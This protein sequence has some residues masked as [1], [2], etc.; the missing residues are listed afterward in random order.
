M[1]GS[2]GNFWAL[3]TQVQSPT[4]FT[5]LIWPLVISPRIR[6][7]NQTKR[8]S[9]PE[10]PKIQEKCNHHPT[11][12]PKKSAPLVLTATAQ[13]LGPLYK[14]YIGINMKGTTLTN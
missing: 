5:C 14:L 10:C 9:F 11:Q 4:L 12:N 13:K 2:I 6:E 1:S 8:A 3:K 7:G